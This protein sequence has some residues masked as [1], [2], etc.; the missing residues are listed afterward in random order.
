MALSGKGLG[1]F[2]QIILQYELSF[3]ILFSKLLSCFLGALSLTRGRVC[4][5]SIQSIVVTQY[6]RKLF[7]SL[8]TGAPRQCYCVL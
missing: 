6:V 3:E 4:L 1:K 7:T 5:L 2:P 8:L